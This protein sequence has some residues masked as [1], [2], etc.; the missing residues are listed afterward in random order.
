MCKDIG[1]WRVVRNAG[2]PEIEV[3]HVNVVDN[4]AQCMSRRFLCFGEYPHVEPTVSREVLWKLS[5]DAL[6]RG[7]QMTEATLAFIRHRMA[8]YGLL[9][10]RKQRE[11]CATAARLRRGRID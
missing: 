4:Y 3:R 1:K 9:G 8:Q 5:C 10:E 6:V 11:C 2:G 7:G